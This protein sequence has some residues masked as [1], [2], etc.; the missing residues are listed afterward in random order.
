MGAYRVIHAGPRAA[1][2]AETL[3]ER[4]VSV[5]RFPG[6][7]L[8]VIPALDQIDAAGAALREAL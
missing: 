3:A 5:R 6:G 7:R 4:G 2:L 1:T 8:G